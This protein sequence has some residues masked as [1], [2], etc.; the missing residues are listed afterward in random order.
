MTDRDTR[1]RVTTLRL[2]EMLELVN[3]LHETL[4]PHDPKRFW[5][6]SQSPLELARQLAGE[7]RELLGVETEHQEFMKVL[8][9]SQ[10]A[11]P[12]LPAMDAPTDSLAGKE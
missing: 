9:N 3:H 11:I 10:A 6:E 2:S 12:P 8:A 7:L 4:L 1:L 5:L